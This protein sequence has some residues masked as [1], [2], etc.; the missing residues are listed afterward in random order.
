[1]QSSLLIQVAFSASVS[2]AMCQA[3]PTLPKPPAKSGE[4]VE[5]TPFSSSPC[6]RRIA[7]S[8]TW[9]MFPRVDAA[10]SSS[11]WSLSPRYM[12]FSN[13]ALRGH[14]SQDWSLPCDQTFGRLSFIVLRP[15]ISSNSFKVVDG[16]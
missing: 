13:H 1:M 3:F 10:K 7:S 11:I 2:K 15:V 5:A 16:G 9:T 12:C 14:S 6:A 8:T 4:G